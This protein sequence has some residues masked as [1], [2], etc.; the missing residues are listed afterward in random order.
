M[1]YLMELSQSVFQVPK[2]KQERQN[3]YWQ[4]H[5]EVRATS[6]L[7]EE[8]NASHFF[9]LWVLLGHDKSLSSLCTWQVFT[10]ISRSL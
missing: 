4:L 5:F 1:V 8:T 2:L 7:E 3:V 10:A 9:L 6:M